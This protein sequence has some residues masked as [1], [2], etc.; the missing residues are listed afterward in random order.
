MGVAALLGRLLGGRNGIASSLIALALGA[1]AMW[2]LPDLLGFGREADLNRE[3]GD[4]KQQ[5][6]DSECQRQQLA[7]I[8]RD[9]AA[10]IDAV[11]ENESVNQE[12]TTADDQRV[13]ALQGRIDS[14]TREIE[15]LRHASADNDAEPAP[16]LIAAIEGIRWGELP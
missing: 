9:Q 15:R 1:L 6:S 5:L 11:A 8:N 7:D 2:Q 4:A 13:A 16:V 3:L 10:A 14:L 12:A